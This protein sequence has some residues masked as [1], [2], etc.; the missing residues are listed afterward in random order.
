MSKS[1]N[2]KPVEE[3]T[4]EKLDH[5]MRSGFLRWRDPHNPKDSAELETELIEKTIQSLKS[6][7]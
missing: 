7:N 3:M 1:T 2:F 4:Q 5:L 6:K